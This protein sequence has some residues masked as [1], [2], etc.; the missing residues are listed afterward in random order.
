VSIPG[1]IRT[2]LALALLA[3]VG[4]ALLVAYAIVIPTLRDS[5]VDAKLNQL[6][7]DAGGWAARLPQSFLWDEYAQDVSYALDARVVVYIVLSPQPPTLSVGGDSREANSRDVEGDPVAERAAETGRTARGTVARGDHRYAEVAFP[8]GTPGPIV[9]AS[10]ALDDQEASVE[11]VERRLL[12]AAAVALLVALVVGYA[13]ASMHA[14]RIRRLERAAER[15]AA[16]HFDEPVVDEGDD[17]LGELARGFD[18]MRIQLAQLDSARKEFIANASHELRTPLFSLGG[19]LELMADE[20]LD[21]ATRT[22][23]V[24]TMREQVERLTKLA[25]DLLDLSRMDA[26]RLRVGVEHVEL[27]DTARTLADELRGLAGTS[28]HPLEVEIDGEPVALADEERVLQVG[29]ALAGNALAHTPPGTRVLVRAGVE[30]GRAVLAVED[31]GPGI[32][33]EHLG[34]IFDRFYRVEGGL[35]SGSG[36]GLAIAREVAELMGGRVTVE[37]RPGRTVFALA[38]EP[39]PETAPSPEPVLV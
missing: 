31:D 35:A 27:G 4:G 29:R 38:L 26:G 23:F 25:T 37:S 13:A 6:E 11:L 18:R 15:I 24:G 21:E 16:G 5:L 10:A 22:E 32:P 1:G 20:D 7:A 19:F 36:L 28:G 12:I 17:E 3:I 39:V 9:L 30:D 34:R 14:R 33:P 2:K 8:L